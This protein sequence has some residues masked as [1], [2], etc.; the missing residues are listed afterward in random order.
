MDL[1]ESFVQRK[2][3]CNKLQRIPQNISTVVEHFFYSLGFR[4][5][6]Q[7]VK[8]IIGCSFVVLICLSGLYKFRQEKNPLKLWVPPDSDFVKDTEWLMSN[9]AEGQRLETAIFTADDVL[10][11]DA[12]YQFNEI[13]KRIIRLQS[14]DEP[15]RYWTDVCF[16]IP[17]ISKELLRQRRSV[18]D[19]DFFDEEP[20]ARANKTKFDP[21]VHAPTDLYCSIVD[22]LQRGCL[23]FSILDIWDFDSDLIKKQTKYDII[24]KINTIK[25]SPTLGHPMNFSDL[26]GDIVTDEAGRIISAKAV[27]SIWM[28]HVNFLNVNMDE[29]GNDV[30][31]AD[32]ATPDVLNWEL[33]FLKELESSSND[34]KLYN[35]KYNKTMGLWYEAGRS[36]GDVSAST[37]YQDILKIATGVILM[38][39]Y[40]LVILSRFTWVE[41]RLCLTGAGLLCVGGAFIVAVGVCSLF[42]VPYGP[43]HTSLPFMLMGL[44]VDDIFVMMASWKQVLTHKQNREKT[45]EE[46]IGL[47]LSHAGAAISITSLTDVVAFIIGAS[48]ILPSLESFCIYA[49]VGVLV[50]FFLQVTFF[51]A[52]FTLD[53]KRIENKRNGIVPCVIHDN[54][55]STILD[56]S[57]SLAWYIIDWFYSKIILTK[58]GKAMIIIITITMTIA[59]S[60]G[61]SQLKQWFDPNWFLPKDSYLTNYMTIHNTHY[62]NRGYQAAVYIGDIDYNDNLKNIIILTENLMNMT[63]YIDHVSPWPI[64]FKNFIHQ[65]YD[66]NILTSSLNNDE[67]YNYLSKFLYS[68]TGGKY[69]RNFYFYN[70]LTCGKN[71]P[72]IKVSSIDFSFKSFT[73]PNEWIPAMDNVKLLAKNSNINGL[74]FVWSR[75]FGS[76]VTDKVIAEEVWRNIVLA[77]ICVMGTTAILIAELQTCIWILMCVG[78]TLVDICGFMYYWGLSIDIVTCIGLELAVGLSVDYAAHVAHAFLNSHGNDRSSRALIAVRHIGA[79]VLYGAGSTLLAQSLMAFSE[80][81]VFQTFWK[82]FVLVIFFGLW[83]GLLLLPVI[84]STIGPSSLHTETKKITQINNDINND[85][86]TEVQVPLTSIATTID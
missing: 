28:L 56:P 84:L 6:K 10:Q 83:H 1:A 57:K 77:L 53:V 86:E 46:K 2:S 14:L 65:N 68:Q 31:T 61:A 80:S 16:K 9:F 11:A 3:I 55:Q 58:Y 15:K 13:T 5:A 64:D 82:I 12:L 22:N 36:F 69:Q 34:L 8:W 47:M 38:S 35:E 72:D 67:L 54:H 40:V 66:K 79:A 37:M 71:A 18:D 44:G 52:F 74:I 75:M 78:L 26:L 20:L 17:I 45:I 76:W 42:G 73:G 43:V 39:I 30:G 25:I 32:W 29:M 63:T 19:D 59:A 23:V 60:F 70:N 81:Y 50:T 33:A 62:P 85:K 4:I 27:K 7:P 51:V 49:A 48:T 41:L 21:S 24:E